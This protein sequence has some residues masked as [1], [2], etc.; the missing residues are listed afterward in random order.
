MSAALAA[1]SAKNK[2]NYDSDIC[3][4]PTLTAYNLAVG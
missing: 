2:K 3:S 1:S 4:A